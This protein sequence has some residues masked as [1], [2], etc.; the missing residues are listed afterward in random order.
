MEGK[1][2][3]VPISSGCKYR[4]E[5]DE[6][7]RNGGNNSNSSNSSKVSSSMPVLQQVRLTTKRSSDDDKTMSDWA[8]ASTPL[9]TTNE[10]NSST[11]NSPASS[12]SPTTTTSSAT[13]LPT[14]SS[15]TAVSPTQAQYKSSSQM[16]PSALLAFHEIF[17]RLDEDMDN[18]LNKEE[19]DSFMLM[20]EG[21]LMHEDVYTWIIQ[22]FETSTGRTSSSRTTNDATAV[23]E[24]GLTRNG[25]VSLYLYMFDEAS[26]NSDYKSEEGEAKKY[27]QNK[28]E[29]VL[30]RDLHF[31]GYNNLLQL[32]RSTSFVLTTHSNNNQLR[33]TK[34]GYD[35]EAYQAAMALPVVTE[36]ECIPL[37]A[38][39]EVVLRKRNNG[40]WGVSFAIENRT[41]KTSRKKKRKD[42][43]KTN[44]IEEDEDDEGQDM[45]FTLDC[46]LSTNVVSGSLGLLNDG[47][48][49][50]TDIVNTVVVKPG[51]IQIVH[52]L[53]PKTQGPWAWKYKASWDFL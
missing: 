14:T 41:K 28:D 20:S 32:T 30:W 44:E 31:M 1:Y 42:K 11:T 38:A 37:D 35:A 25:F 22:H 19:L 29:N 10:K 49:G 7:K 2:V 47:G 50:N 12:S 33:V 43:T 45:T 39:G 53:I 13:P 27:N 40:Y 46:S 9:G 36:G 18:V 5:A 8:A 4:H 3:I 51:E 15:T 48:K 24:V 23:G 34:V 21:T 16:T 6:M 17:H 26:G 52:H